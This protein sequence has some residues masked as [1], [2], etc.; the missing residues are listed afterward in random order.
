MTFD[1]WILPEEIEITIREKLNEYV[2]ELVKNQPASISSLETPR[3]PIQETEPIEPQP[4]KQRGKV[5]TQVLTDLALWLAS[6][7]HQ[8][9]TAK[10]Q[11]TNQYFFSS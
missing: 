9:I 3:L 6:L 7:Q 2:Q 4:S 1:R 11:E 5:I 10:S 8:K